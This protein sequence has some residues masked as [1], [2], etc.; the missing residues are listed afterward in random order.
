MGWIEVK[1]QLLT[2]VIGVNTVW[3]LVS[4]GFGFWFSYSLELAGRV[5]V[6]GYF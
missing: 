6:F 1:Q 2:L 3:A 4:Y 5:Q